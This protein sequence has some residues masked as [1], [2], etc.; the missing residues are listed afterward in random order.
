MTYRLRRTKTSNAPSRL[1]K[2][3]KAPSSPAATAPTFCDARRTT[4]KSISR[5]G[6]ITICGAEIRPS[7]RWC[8][9]WRTLSRR[10]SWTRSSGTLREA[11][12]AE[13]GRGHDEQ[14]R[15]RHR[16]ALAQQRQAAGAVALRQHGREHGK[17]RA[18][19]AALEQLVAFGQHQVALAPE[20]DLLLGPSSTFSLRF[21]N[22]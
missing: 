10:S 8:L 19:S 22:L 4:K 12:S 1:A 9:C 20:V 3:P 21:M 6:R 15:R 7:G 11:G 2:S 18:M 17:P 5:R 13:K 14:P 16:A